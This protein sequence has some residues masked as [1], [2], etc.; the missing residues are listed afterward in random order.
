M[1]T[2]SYEPVIM[3][4]DGYNVG[5]GVGPMKKKWKKNETLLILVFIFL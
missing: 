5:E 4:H 2:L 3:N 1:F